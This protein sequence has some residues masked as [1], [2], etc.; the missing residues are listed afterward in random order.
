MKAEFIDDIM[1][2][3]AEDEAET[4]ALKEWRERKKLS[5]KRWLEVRYYNSIQVIII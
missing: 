1:V 5:K 2:I 4:V 3:K